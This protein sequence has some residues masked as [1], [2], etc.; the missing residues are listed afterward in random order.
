MLDGKD[1]DTQSFVFLLIDRFS[2]IAFASAIEPLRIANRMAQAPLYHWR[3][4]TPDGEPAR[5]SNGTRLVADCGMED[6][7]KNAMIM[8]CGGLDIHRA[9][10]PSVMSWLRKQSRRG[11]ALGAVC[12]APFILAKAGLLDNARCTIHWENR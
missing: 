4:A 1:V 8:V 9:A 10:T 6:L 2:M 5:C 7:D 11:V 3:I 12:T